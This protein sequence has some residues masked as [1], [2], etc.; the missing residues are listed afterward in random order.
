MI[1]MTVEQI[2]D[3]LRDRNIQAVAR[4]SGV[5]AGAIYRLMQDG[6]NPLHD[7]VVRLSN[8]LSGTQPNDK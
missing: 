5:S 7:T 8:Y 1:V 3:A 4:A 6:A 2:R